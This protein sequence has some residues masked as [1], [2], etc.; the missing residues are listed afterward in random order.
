MEMNYDTIQLYG[1]CAVLFA[2][3]IA[4]AIRESYNLIKKV[5]RNIE[6]YVEDLKDLDHMIRD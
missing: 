1:A 3:F 6:R 5:N 2:G 4:P